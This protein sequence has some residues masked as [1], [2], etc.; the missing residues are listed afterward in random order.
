MAQKIPFLRLFSAWRP[1]AELAAL[2]ERYLVT[3][4]VID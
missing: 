2:V 3:G 4:A 1:P